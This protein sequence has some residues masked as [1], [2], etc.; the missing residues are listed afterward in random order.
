[1]LAVTDVATDWLNTE[2]TEAN[3]DNIEKARKFLDDRISLGWTN[4]DQA[5]DTILRK[6][7]ANSQVVYIGDGIITAGDRDP[8]AFAKRFA[9]LIADKK[10]TDSKTPDLTFHT[11]TV[12]NS[13]RSGRAKGN[14]QHW[15]WFF[16]RDW[17]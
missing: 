13:E 15:R 14:C 1:M 11:I 4:L 5:F 7:P 8:A 6:A 16:S 3:S 2:M 9:K 10:N 12:G 17:R